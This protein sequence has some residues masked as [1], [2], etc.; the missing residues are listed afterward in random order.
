M[1]LSLIT[2]LIYSHLFGMDKTLGDEIFL[3]VGA[4]SWA[5]IHFISM[6]KDLPPIEKKA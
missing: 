5:T 6:L 1:V 4:T 3:T 2:T